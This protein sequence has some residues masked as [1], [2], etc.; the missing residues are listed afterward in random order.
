MKWADWITK[1]TMFVINPCWQ[2]LSLLSPNKSSARRQKGLT[3]YFFKFTDRPFCFRTDEVLSSVIH[4]LTC[5][6]QLTHKLS[7]IGCT[8]SLHSIYMHLRMTL[9]LHASAGD[10]FSLWICRCT[11]YKWHFVCIHL[12]MAFHL[13]AS[14]DDIFNAS[15]DDIFS[16]CIYRFFRCMHPQMIFSLR[17]SAGNIALFVSAGD[18]LCACHR[19]HFAF[20]PVRIHR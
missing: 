12:Q 13:H 16:A 18:I 6:P 14:T 20:F 15:T 9:S 11:V 10:I 8:C 2:G 3:G 7:F 17:A 1:E 5:Q 19:W 4:L